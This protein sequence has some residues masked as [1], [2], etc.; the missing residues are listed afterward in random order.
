MF[1]L[2][3]LLATGASVASGAV[4]F[5][6][7]NYKLD[8]TVSLLGYKAHLEVSPRKFNIDFS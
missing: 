1:T 6:F 8:K 5:G 2:I 3:G 7:V 4:Y